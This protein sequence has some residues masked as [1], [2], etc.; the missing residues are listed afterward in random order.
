MEVSSWNP[1]KYQQRR[2]GVLKMVVLSNNI[3][4]YVVLYSIDSCTCRWALQGVETR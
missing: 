3:T 2:N 4:A 1:T